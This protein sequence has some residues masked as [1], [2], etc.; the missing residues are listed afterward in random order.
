MRYTIQ[1]FLA[2]VCKTLRPMLSDR[3]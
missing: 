3:C 2:A 1:S